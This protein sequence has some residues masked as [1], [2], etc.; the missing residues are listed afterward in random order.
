MDLE[1]FKKLSEKIGQNTA[2]PQERITFM[3]ELNSIA[4]DIG[5]TLNESV[6]TP[7]NN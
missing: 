3:T 4:T 2:T 7:D 6:Q 1:E 5:S